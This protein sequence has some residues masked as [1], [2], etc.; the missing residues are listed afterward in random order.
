MQ[1]L[2]DGR[3]ITKKCPNFKTSRAFMFKLEIDN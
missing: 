2:N 1:L 3:E